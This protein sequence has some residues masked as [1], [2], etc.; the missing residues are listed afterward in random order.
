MKKPHQPSSQI[1]TAMT[2]SAIAGELGLVIAVPLIIFV[3]VGIRVDQYL[4]TLPLFLIAGMLLA[5][6]T[7]T[8]VIARKI[9]L[10]HQ[11]ENE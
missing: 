1:V 7:S 9:K 5:L 4:H 6:A 11:I 10:L 3:I 8:A 2:L